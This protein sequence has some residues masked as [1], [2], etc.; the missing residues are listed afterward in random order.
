VAGRQVLLHILPGDP[1]F[2]SPL[3]GL[4]LYT[5]SFI[6]FAAVGGILAAMLVLDAQF[7]PLSQPPVR[8]PLSRFAGA[9]VWLFLAVAA[10]NVATTLLLCGLGPCEGDPTRYLWLS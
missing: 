9:V 2:G 4:H 7:A 6:A 8:L 10:A 3:L 1:G 5:W